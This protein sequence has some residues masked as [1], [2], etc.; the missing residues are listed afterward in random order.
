M[1]SPL[2]PP[3]IPNIPETGNS[4]SAA[5]IA[6]A[7]ANRMASAVTRASQ[8]ASGGGSS[9]V[10]DC[11]ADAAGQAKVDNIRFLADSHNRQGAVRASHANLPC[12][13]LIL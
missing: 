11:S 5:V 6:F 4:C 2:R 10:A 7:A 3:K 9:C 8:E 12:K 13:P 1:I